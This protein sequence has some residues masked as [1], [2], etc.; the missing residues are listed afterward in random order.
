MAS[1]VDPN[2]R[3]V[4]QL[5]STG[6]SLFIVSVVGGVLSLLVVGLRTFSRV[7][8]RNFGLDD[9]LMLGGLVSTAFAVCALKGACMAHL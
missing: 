7:R 3:Y 9:G 2:Q 6:L 1:A 5:E 4:D 8:A